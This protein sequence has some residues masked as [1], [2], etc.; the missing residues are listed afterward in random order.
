MTRLQDLIPAILVG[1][2][3]RV[4][5]A[6]ETASVPSYT[7][8]A[9][10]PIVLFLAGLAAGVTMVL[11]YG[12]VCNGPGIS[13]PFQSDPQQQTHISGFAL[14]NHHSEALRNSQ[15]DLEA[16][17]LVRKRAFDS[18]AR[19]ARPIWSRNA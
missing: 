16:T 5:H 3:S 11:C 15:V 7:T 13:A 17:A 12:L 4:R 19:V 10:L 2:A 14:P 18:E 8:L 1:S 6:G 9:Y